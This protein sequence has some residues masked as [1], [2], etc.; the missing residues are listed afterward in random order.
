[1]S[2]LALGITPVVAGLV[3]GALQ[4]APALRR[5]AWHRAVGM[6]LVPLG[7]LAVHHLRSA[8]Q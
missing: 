8:T 5:R 4:F 1:M 3:L 6:A 7:L 2:V